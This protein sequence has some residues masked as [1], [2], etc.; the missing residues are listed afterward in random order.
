MKNERLI[1]SITS[2]CEF[3][4]NCIRDCFCAFISFALS[5]Y[6]SS[7]HLI[8]LFFSFITLRVSESNPNPQ[9]QRQ[10]KEK[11]EKSTLLSI[12]GA[13]AYGMSVRKSLYILLK[14]QE[15]RPQPKGEYIKTFKFICLLMKSS[16]N[17]TYGENM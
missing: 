16:N 2:E 9:S 17:K 5:C 3:K 8:C 12:E 10:K 1:F 7:F 15:K 11:S 14:I 13:E 6:S 4:Q